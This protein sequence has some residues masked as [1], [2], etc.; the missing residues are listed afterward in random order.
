MTSSTRTYLVFTLFVVLWC[1]AL[2]AAPLAAATFG[3]EGFLASSLYSFFGR[4]CHQLAVRSFHIAGEQL[5]VCIRCS[6][7]Y[8]SFL[9]GLLLYPVLTRTAFLKRLPLSWLLIPL[10]A[11][12]LDVALNVTGVVTSSELSRIMTGSLVGFSLSLFLT[13]TLIEAV[14]GLTHRITIRG[15]SSYAGETE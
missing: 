11:M 1:A 13:P 15:D 6:S 7:I 14:D 2:V 4:V 9:A 10:A 5:G 8:V 3:R 12:V